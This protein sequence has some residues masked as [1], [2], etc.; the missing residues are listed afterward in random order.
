MSGYSKACCTLPPAVAEDYTT[1]G[2][3]ETIGGLKTYVTGDKTASKAIFLLYD[4]F[5]YSPPTL[6]GADIISAAGYLLVIP[7]LLNSRLAQA[8]WFSSTAEEDVKTKNEFMAYI[9]DMPQH[10][11][12]FKTSLAAL[13]SEYKS[14]EKWGSIGCE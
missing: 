8:Q 1:K 4:I 5:G 3:Y 10:L 7:D 9:G 11:Q 2:S 14:V 6:Q 12:R 13:K